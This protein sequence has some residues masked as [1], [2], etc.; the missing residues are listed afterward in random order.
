MQLGQDSWSDQFVEAM[1]VKGGKV[2]FTVQII[3]PDP[4]FIN[5][6]N[7]IFFLCGFSSS[8]SILY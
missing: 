6:V 1:N 5:L 2:R 8:T 7:Y 3:W 4:K